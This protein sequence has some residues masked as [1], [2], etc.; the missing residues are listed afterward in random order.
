MLSKEIKLVK[1]K[2]TSYYDLLSFLCAH[3]AL[4]SAIS[5]VCCLHL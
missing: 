3:A 4:C 5:D 1:N 2:Y